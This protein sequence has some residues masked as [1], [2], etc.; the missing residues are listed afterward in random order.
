MMKRSH[1]NPDRFTV[2]WLVAVLFAL[3]VSSHSC[4]VAGPESGLGDFGEIDEAAAR[5]SFAAAGV[6]PPRTVFTAAETGR[7]DPSRIR[8]AVAE[9]RRVPASELAEGG[10]IGAVP[11][12]EQAGAP[13]LALEESSVDASE[14]KVWNGSTFED[15]DEDGEGESEPE[16]AEL[17]VPLASRIA[18]APRIGKILFEN[19][20]GAYE[21]L[22][23][24]ALRLHVLVDGP[25]ARTVVDMVFSNPHDEQLEGTFHYP[26]PAGASAAGFAMFAGT[27]RIEDAEF[28]D[29]ALLPPLPETP[30]GADEPGEAITRIERLA[31]AR[32]DDV[33]LVPAGAL[34][35]DWGELQ[36]A[37]VVEQKRAREIYETIVRRQIDPALLEWA[38]ANT[39]RARVFPIEASSV[40]RVV[41]AYE[42]TLPL[43]GDLMRYTYAL[44]R[45]ETLGAIDVRLILNGFGVDLEAIAGRGDSVL[46]PSSAEGPWTVHDVKYRAGQDD[47]VD[48][49]LRPQDPGAQVIEIDTPDT[50]ATF[51]TR[52]RPPFQERQRPDPT[53]RVLFV[54]DTSLSGERRSR[55]SVDLLRTILERDD[56]ITEYGVLLFD[57]RPRWL[58]AA[59]WRANDAA[60]RAETLAEL[61]N[62]FL[63]GATSFEAV[64]D[65]LDRQRDW[66]LDRG[67]ARA[68]LLSDGFVTWGQDR[69]GELI[70][71]Y[72]IASRLEWISYELGTAAVDRQL[73]DALARASGGRVVTIL[74]R[75]QIEAGA[76]AHRKSQALIE[77]IAVVGSAARDVVVAGNPRFLFPGQ[78][79]RIAGRLIDAGSA[80]EVVVRASIDGEP[81][82]WRIPLA[83]GGSSPLAA[84]AWAELYTASLLA[85]DDDRLDR[86]I[87]ALSQRFELA[88]RVASFLVLESQQDYEEFRVEDEL[89][90][91]EDLQ[92]VRVREEDRR[93]DRLQGI[94]LDEA[95]PHAADV[96]R[97][98]AALADPDRDRFP[99]QP[100]VDRPLAGGEPRIAAELAYRG[101][102]G[103]ASFGE[104][105]ARVFDTIARVRALSGDT[106]GALRAYSSIVE[107]MPAS[108]ETMRFAGYACLALGVHDAAAE[109]FERV[110]LQRPFEPQSYLEEALALDAAGRWSEAARNYEIVLAREFARHE[111]ACH[112]VAAVRYSRLLLEASLRLAGTDDETAR[113]RALVER[114]L[115]EVAAVAGEEQIGPTDL[116]LAVH[117]N[118]D[119]T[120]IDLHVVEPEGET[121]S[122]QQLTTRAGGRLS[123]DVTDG[124]GP[125]LYQ[126]AQIAA[127]PTAP[128]PD[129]PR[130]FR[131]LVHYYGNNS[132]RWSVPTCVL[133]VADRGLTMDRGR[134][135]DRTF[136]LRLLAEEDAV[137]EIREDVLDIP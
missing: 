18:D 44:P 123:G 89:V 40:K 117:W 56:T 109:I 118:T 119:G 36:L 15:A 31:L 120:D 35:E 30:R 81:L 21:S 134:N 113:R 59:G 75:E 54:V 9:G 70:R 33:G 133:I 95:P 71:R 11:S 96:V 99:G 24:R 122:Y 14:A 76:L 28:G 27:S 136:Q 103:E 125:E 13:T 8:A 77:E 37:R 98:I 47:L 100:L 114:R 87:T 39:F 42:Q 107:Q 91:L 65:E 43:D 3:L 78:E 64:L 131:T 73:L 105:G 84:R 82:A 127:S 104:I 49:A 128:A 92:S 20:E 121:C 102:R 50:G 63:E 124:Y 74:T 112:A 46:I 52:V 57:I 94:A 2:A 110:R 129:G 51:F 48:I 17:P 53:A 6:E 126:R 12:E 41:L 93:R 19:D 108:A 80:A 32:P 34:V 115:R 97:T 5:A 29:R 88:N 10:E 130:R 61:E 38:G 68:F 106:L 132:S 7:I 55:L 4:Q 1:P 101:A 135:R 67:P 86:M 111:E 22:V 69:A 26:L 60:S 79:L 72:P 62:V 23:P 137:F 58:H 90:D 85:L 66:L 83:C 16:S 25:R 45:E 116:Q